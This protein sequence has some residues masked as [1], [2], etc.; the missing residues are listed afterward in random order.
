MPQPHGCGMAAD[1]PA[2]VPKADTAMEDY[3]KPAEQQPED[4]AL[5]VEYLEKMPPVVKKTDISS[6]P[7][8]RKNKRV[9]ETLDLHG[10]TVEEA[11]AAVR[12]FIAANR[13]KNNTCIKIITGKG[14]HSGKGPVLNVTIKNGLNH[15]RYGKISRFTTA[16]AREGGSG[17]VIITL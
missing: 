5:F 10:M 14:I 4:T 7:V 8:P 9:Q 12:H 3:Y 1:S 6:A 13:K 17:A 11:E 16:P 15:G 2:A